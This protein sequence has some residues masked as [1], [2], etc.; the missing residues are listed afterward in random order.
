MSRRWFCAR[1]Y[2]KQ[3]KAMVSKGMIN[4]KTWQRISWSLDKVE[5]VVKYIKSS[6]CIEN[7][8]VTRNILLEEEINKWWTVLGSP[9]YLTTKKC[10]IA[11]HSF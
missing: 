7:E 5:V 11:P 4:A 3:Q 9:G 2:V 1:G 6:L 10:T 8:T